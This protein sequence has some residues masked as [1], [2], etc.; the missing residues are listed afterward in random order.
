MIKLSLRNNVLC[1][2]F[3]EMFMSYAAFPCQGSKADPALTIPK[4]SVMPLQRG[5]HTHWLGLNFYFWSKM[6]V[7]WGKLILFKFAK[8]GVGQTTKYAPQEK[9]ATSLLNLSHC[10]LFWSNSV[11]SL[12]IQIQAWAHPDTEV[13]AFH[14]HIK[15]ILS[16]SA[17]L[18]LSPHPQPFYPFAFLY[19]IPCPCVHQQL[20]LLYSNQV[21]SFKIKA[22]IWPSTDQHHQT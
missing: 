1:L 20:I 9:T 11:V 2:S 21:R 15:I 16:K 22:N 18:L 19:N 3:W 4:S 5:A 6:L 7:S 17:H 13:K 14:M 8:F 12:A 10:L